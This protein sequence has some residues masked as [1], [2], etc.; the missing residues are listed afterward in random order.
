MELEFQPHVQAKLDEMARASGRP[1]QELVEDALIGYFDELTRTREM[2]DQRF[3][4]LESGRA[5]PIEGEEAYR[6][7]MEKTEAERCR[8]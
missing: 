6:L 8:P 2:L 7:L 3:D 1:S 5:T 4:D